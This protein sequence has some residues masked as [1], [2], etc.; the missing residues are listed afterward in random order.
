[1]I[2]A[3]AAEALLAGANGVAIRFSHRELA[4]IRGA[5]LRFALAAVL[6][7][8][9]MLALRLALP[10]GRALLGAMLFGLYRSRA[11]LAYS[12]MDSFR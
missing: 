6:I 1:M 11:P 10:R 4:S 12:T 5:G 8:S 2:L 3:F 9:V 7:V